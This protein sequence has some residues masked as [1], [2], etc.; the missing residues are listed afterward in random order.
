MSE[1][2]DLKEDNTNSFEKLEKI[3]F[4]LKINFFLIVIIILFQKKNF[5]N[6]YQI[7][8]KCSLNLLKLT[9]QEEATIV[10]Y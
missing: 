9:I 6:R 5:I 1:I 3:Y 8:E 2:K 4:L 7:S 10:D